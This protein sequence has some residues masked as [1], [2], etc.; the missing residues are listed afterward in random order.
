MERNLMYNA[1]V[2]FRGAVSS[3]IITTGILRGV[4]QGARQTSATYRDDKTTW[5]RE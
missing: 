1:A 5:P 4:L 3:S 2:Y